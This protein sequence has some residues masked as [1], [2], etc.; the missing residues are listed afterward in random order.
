MDIFKTKL[1]DNIINCKNYFLGK[2]VILLSCGPNIEKYK[3]FIDYYRNKN[4]LLVVI[5]TATNYSNYSEDI[6]F[7]DPRLY[8]AHRTDF[9]YSLNKKSIKILCHDFKDSEFKC[10]I[11]PDIELYPLSNIN[12]IQAEISDY[13][14]TKNKIY[15]NGNKLFP[16]ILKAIHFLCFLGIKD[17]RLFGC[18]WYN[19]NLSTQ[20]KHFEKEA[21][22]KIGFDNL[23]GSFYCNYMLDKYIKEFNLNIILYSEYSQITTSIPRRNLKNETFYQKSNYYLN[24]KNKFIINSNYNKILQLCQNSN[25][26]NQEW[27]IILMKMISN[28]NKYK[29]SL[30]DRII[31]PNNC[32]PLIYI[33]R[34][35]GLNILI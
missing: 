22:E 6:F 26:I 12:T 19:K 21:Q 16:I 10:D 32:D 20:A 11:T 13:I 14:F 25:F 23:I 34:L 28:I 35:I 31:I 17:I 27:Y 3:Y 9:K 30:I 2:K 4:T 1:N 33:S 5:K 15:Q 18:D 8:L 24:C 7:Y 29:Y